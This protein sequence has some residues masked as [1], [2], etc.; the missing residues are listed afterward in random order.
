LDVVNPTLP[1]VEMLLGRGAR[2]LSPPT[3]SVLTLLPEHVVI[4]ADDEKLIAW[5]A[6]RSPERPEGEDSVRIPRWTLP[7]IWIPLAALFLGVLPWA[8]SQPGARYGWTSGRPSLGNL[9]G[10][11]PLAMGFFCLAWAFALHFASATGGWE[12]A[13]TQGY[14]VVRGPY[15]Y[16]R[17][18]MYLGGAVIWLGWSVLYGSAIIASVFLIWVA[19]TNFAIIPWEERSLEKAFG[20][21]YRQ[22][23]DSVPR[24][25]PRPR[26]RPP[27]RRTQ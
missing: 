19:V 3:S 24:W 20:E 14:L 21:G 2:R 16:T 8:L 15:R 4:A 13:P 6:G 9:A 25:I 7:L 17:N 26:G 10:T 18:P 1:A 27:V 5:N 22:Y 12:V 23:R 11:I